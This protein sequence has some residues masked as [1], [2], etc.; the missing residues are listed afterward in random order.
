[1][2]NSTTT[3]EYRTFGDH[4]YL[5]TSY[6]RLSQYDLNGSLG[7]TDMEAVYLD[8]KDKS[9]LTVFPNPTTGLISVKGDLV[10]LSTFQLTNN[11]GKDVKGQVAVYNQ[12]T[13]TIVIDLKDLDA[14]VY[15]VTFAGGSIPVVKY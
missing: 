15:F 13:D 7:T 1:M 12:S 14:G 11:V 4:P 5:G 3:H 9:S 10:S 8:V 2:G 6:Y